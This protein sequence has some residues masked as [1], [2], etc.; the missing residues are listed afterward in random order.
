MESEAFLEASLPILGLFGWNHGTF[1]I[2]CTIGLE[3]MRSRCNS[4]T[5]L[6]SSLHHHHE[7]WLCHKTL[8]TLVR[9]RIRASMALLF[10]TDPDS[11]ISVEYTTQ[12]P[13]C[14]R[15]MCSLAKLF[16]QSR[17]RISNLSSRGSFPQ[18]SAKLRMR[19]IQSKQAF[20]LK[21]FF[22]RKV[23]TPIQSRPFQKS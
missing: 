9:E 1:K 16:H 3:H 11:P 17:L 10:H 7:P 14:R 6:C 8:H 2:S 23:S 12:D 21:C 18:Y 5:A 13:P 4:R 15:R 20:Y 22:I 19:Q